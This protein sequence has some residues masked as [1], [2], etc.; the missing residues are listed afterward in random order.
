MSAT[1]WMTC[2][3]SR[4]MHQPKEGAVLL[5]FHHGRRLAR[6]VPRLALDANK[7]RVALAGVLRES[8]LQRRPAHTISARAL[9]RT[10]N[11]GPLTCT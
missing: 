3:V 7:Q 10:V 4:C 8:V 11:F 2:S 1:S 6:S 5:Q 9:P